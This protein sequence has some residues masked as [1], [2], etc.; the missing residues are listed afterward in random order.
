MPSD[1]NGTDS[2][3]V[4]VCWGGGAA[5]G[6]PSLEPLRFKQSTN[7][8]S[9]EFKSQLRQL[10]LHMALKA[11]EHFDEPGLIMDK[12]SNLGCG[13]REKV[14][15]AMEVHHAGGNPVAAVVQPG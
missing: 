9:V 2:A 15:L 3:A 8:G 14:M 5:A 1:L 7:H 11:S 4:L 12:F 13:T 6:G 10:I